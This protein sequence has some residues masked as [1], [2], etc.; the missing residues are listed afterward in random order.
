MVDFGEGYGSS[1]FGEGYGT[2]FLPPF[3]ICCQRLRASVVAQWEFDPIADETTI[4]IDGA[5][6]LNCSCK[7]GV[8]EYVCK[9]REDEPTYDTIFYDTPDGQLSLGGRMEWSHWIYKNCGNCILEEWQE[10][11]ESCPCPDKKNYYP[12]VKDS[13]VEVEQGL[14]S[15]SGVFGSECLKR[16]IEVVGV[17][18]GHRDSKDAMAEIERQVDLARADLPDCPRCEEKGK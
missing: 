6:Y 1:R 15:D 4:K 5:V 8:E 2:S 18:S 16:M 7:R 13:P 12:Y 17:V 10:D 14:M 9:S 3:D 11:T